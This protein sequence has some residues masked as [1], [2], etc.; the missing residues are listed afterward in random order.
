MDLIYTNADWEDVGILKD[1]VFDL[2]FGSD[3]ND[4]ELNVSAGN[5]CCVNGC[6]VY[7]EGT[8]YGGIIDRISVATRDESLTYA[9][10]TWH[11]VLAS[12]IIQPASGEAYLTVSGEANAVIGSLIDRIGL[13]GLFA[14]S[15]EDSGMT[16]SEYSF[17]RYIDA[18][19]GMKKMLKAVSGKLTFTFKTDKVIVSAL[20][21]VDYSE[22]EQFNDD[23][24]EMEV[25]RTYNTVNH[26]ICLGKGNLEERQVVHLYLDEAG[27]ISESQTFA[28]LEEIMDIY[29]CSNAESLE[30]LEKGG[31]EKLAEHVLK[32][33]SV[34]MDFS[35][36]EKVYDIGDII[37]T[38]ETITGIVAI[39]QINKKIVT[40]KKGTVNIEYKVGE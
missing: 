37:G 8:E 16:I 27:N 22:D 17:D 32:K 14:A 29:D 3:E 24:V 4:F 12:K 34:Q 30:E 13:S 33:N 9:G 11:G 1:Y 35:S 18:Y 2:A 15:S 23:Q 25:S 38:M 7:I 21:I 40:I 5:H 39:E 6:L 26:L 19:N 31:K 36:E 10:R 20:P 28:G